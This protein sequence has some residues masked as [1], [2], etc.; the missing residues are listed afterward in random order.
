VAKPGALD[1]AVK[2]HDL[3][4]IAD[5]G[6][7]PPAGLAVYASILLTAL[8]VAVVWIAARRLMRR[9]A[10]RSSGGD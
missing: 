3:H 2:A 6:Y 5:C 4:C 7:V 1:V 9:K 10:G 8:V